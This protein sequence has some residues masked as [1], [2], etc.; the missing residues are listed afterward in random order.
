[1]ELSIAA[2][3]SGRHPLAALSTHRFG[4]AETDEALRTL[5]GQGRP[6]AIHCTVYP[7]Q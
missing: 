5:A 1:V 4:L 6:N 7:W 2:I 3:A